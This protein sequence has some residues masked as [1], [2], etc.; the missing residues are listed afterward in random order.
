MRSDYLR[1]PAAVVQHP[2]SGGSELPRRWG[3]GGSRWF[4]SDGCTIPDQSTD[5][6]ADWFVQRSP[7][8]VV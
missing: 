5:G 7:N 3:I 4:W 1:W 6:A 8:S 2:W